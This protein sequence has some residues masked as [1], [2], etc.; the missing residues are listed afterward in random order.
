MREVQRGRELGGRGGEEKCYRRQQYQVPTM[1]VRA[2]SPLPHSQILILKA[3]EKRRFQG[4]LFL[5]TKNTERTLVTGPAP[6]LGW[7]VRPDPAPHRRA[8]SQ[9]PACLTPAGPTH[10]GAVTVPILQTRKWRQHRI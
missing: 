5:T 7:G 8:H 9:G 2:S 10:L 3:R 4:A 6:R 1:D